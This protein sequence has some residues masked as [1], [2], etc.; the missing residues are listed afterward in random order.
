M[1]SMEMSH[2]S[3]WES[4][5]FKPLAYMLC[6]ITAGAVC[7]KVRGSTQGAGLLEAEDKPVGAMRLESKVTSI[8]RLSWLW[9]YCSLVLLVTLG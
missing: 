8:P 2:P 5:P 1:R 3:G 6:Q 9:G 4:G 7:T